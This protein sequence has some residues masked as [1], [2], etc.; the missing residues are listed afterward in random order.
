M[1]SR[2][3]DTIDERIA[4]EIK[5]LHQKHPALGNEGLSKALEQQGIRVDEHQL[6]LFLRAKRI[7]PESPG[8]KSWGHVAAGY[9]IGGA[10]G[11]G[12]Y[13]PGDE[14]SGGDGDGGD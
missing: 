1:T 2:Q 4:V 9:W 3:Y 14:G 10:L 6:K 7:H 11:D 12:H 5:R 13:D 8:R